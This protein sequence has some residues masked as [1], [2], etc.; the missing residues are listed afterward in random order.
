MGKK[1]A[2]KLA[3]EL[4]KFREGA[5]K[6]GYTADHAEEIFH[7]LEP[8][9]GYGFNKSHAVAYSIVAYQT[10]YLKANYPTEFLAA[11]LTNE[12]NNPD[13]FKEYLNLAPQINIKILPP[14]INKS[15]TYFGVSDGNIVYGLAGI[16]NVGANVVETIVREREKNGP[17]TSFMDFISRMPESPN[18]RLLESLIKAGTFDELGENRATLIANLDEALNYD[19]ATREITAGGQMSLFGDEEPVMN[20]FTMRRVE[21]WSKE[22]KL[23]NEKEMLGFYISGHPLDAYEDKIRECVRVR[24]DHQEDIP[25]FKTTPLIALVTSIR[26]IKFGD[27]KKMGVY[28]LQTKDGEIEATAFQK[29]YEQISSRVEVDGIYAFKGS[30]KYR[31]DMLGFIIE[32]VVDPASLVPENINSISIVLKESRI[33]EDGY[34]AELRKTLENQSGEIPVHLI[35]EG[36]KKDVKLGFDMRMSYSTD[37]IKELKELG[38]V[39][40]VRIY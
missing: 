25:L 2:D 8:F 19:K 14:S 20:S 18:T 3:E 4:V 7:I 26:M 33:L 11:N 23:K 16:K 13:K 1:Q 5:V 6:R 9:A 22:E 36:Q 30:F 35:L 32:D 29:V 38:I 10:A 28:N 27:N 40:S 21:D 31:N 24:L 37:N 17:F 15:L 12:M 39:E 34:L